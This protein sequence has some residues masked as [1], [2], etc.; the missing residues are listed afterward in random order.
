[1]NRFLAIVFIFLFKASSA[2]ESPKTD[3]IPLPDIIFLPRNPHSHPDFPVFMVKELSVKYRSGKN[4]RKDTV[5]IV[6]YEVSIHDASN[7]VD[8]I[9]HVT[10][11]KLPDSY[12][13]VLNKCTSGTE[14]KFY[15][16]KIYEQYRKPPENMY[17]DLVDK[18][19]YEDEPRPMTVFRFICQ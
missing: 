5:R 13:Q 18:Y 16:I 9:L 7:S 15:S 8:T 1:M 4:L 2:Q 19:I 17:S 10:G 14:V 12:I 11:S 3:N 6:S